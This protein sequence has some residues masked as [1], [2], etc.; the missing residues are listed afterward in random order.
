MRPSLK[1]LYL[2]VGMLLLTACQTTP[3]KA[4]PGDAQWPGYTLEQ[5]PELLEQ[6]AEA[7]PAESADLML[8]AIEVLL[9]NGETDWARNIIAGMKP[10]TL[11]DDS[12][13]RH[14]LLASRLAVASGSRFTAVHLLSE[15]RLLEL[16]PTLPGELAVDLREQRARVY[17]SIREYRASV[18]ERVRLDQLLVDGSTSLDPVKLTEARNLNHDALWQTLMQLS[19]DELNQLRQQAETPVLE[20][21]YTLAGLSKNNQSNLNKQLALVNE[22]ARNWPAHPASL[23]LPADLQLLRD[24]V[25]NQ[26]R[27]VALLLPLTGPLEGASIAIRDGFMAAFYNAVEHGEPVPDIHVYDTGTMDVQSAYDRAIIDGAETVVGPLEKE[28]IAELA[29]RPELPVPTLALNYADTPYGDIK[30]LYQFGLAVEDEAQQVAQ[31]AW[32]DGHRRALILAPASSWG[33]RSVNTFWE[34]WK[35]LGGEVTRDY[36]FDNNDGYLGVIA[37][38]LHISDSKQRARHIRQM[39]GRGVEFEPRRRQ[40][41]DMI[42]L[43]AHTQQARQIKPTLAFHYAGNIPVY[44]TSQIYSGEDPTA[45]QDMNGIRFTSLPWFFA[46]NAPERQALNRYANTA[47][48]YQRLYA[49]GVDAFHLYP[50]LRQLR[51]VSRARYYGYTGALSL[52]AAG[53]IEREQIWAQFVGDEVRAMP[54]LT[55]DDSNFERN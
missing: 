39:L 4:P 18:Q 55:E 35:T 33:D 41:V 25:K 32:R 3:D 51:E 43:V 50:R 28:T 52:N 10:A 54:T 27:Q 24:L 42:F 46:E 12:Y 15:Q 31:Q 48:S 49:L 9:F 44:A 7:P 2:L 20:G 22:W 26:P 36:R 16:L 21:W 29:L 45:N 8:D 34:E 40:D 30:Q 19:H 47:A 38:A 17:D 5:V 37:S 1:H 14:Q 6:A 53:K 11:A 23:R 13:A